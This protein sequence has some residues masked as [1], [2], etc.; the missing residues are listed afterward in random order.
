VELGHQLQT[1]MCTGVKSMSSID[2]NLWVFGLVL[3]SVIMGI[4][5]VGSFIAMGIIIYNRY[6]G[7]KKNKRLKRF[8]I[9]KGDKKKNWFR[10]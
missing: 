8:K 1:T 4:V 7:H 6:T 2:A 10:E 9:I 5:V 3:T